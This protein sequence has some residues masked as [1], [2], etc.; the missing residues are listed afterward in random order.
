MATIVTRAGKGSPLTHD[1]VDD[2]FDNL[3]T[4]KVETSAIGTAAAANTGDFATAAQGTLADSAVQT[5]DSPTFAGL[6]TTADV[7][8]GDNDKAIFGAGSDLQIYHDNAQSTNFLI[9][10]TSAN[11]T[12]GTSGIVNVGSSGSN[13][14]VNGAVALVQGNDQVSLSGATVTTTTGTNG[15]VLDNNGSSKLATTATGIDVTGSISVSGTVDGRDV[16]AD[17]TKLDGIEASA[18]VTD[19]ANVTAAG[20]LMDSEVTNLAQVK[21][22]DSS[23]YATAAQGTL[24]DSAVQPNDSPTF[25]AVIATSYAG[26]GSALTGLPAGYTDADVDTHL[27]T[28]TA[29][30]GE[31]LSWTGTDY[32][33]IA[34]GGGGTALELYAEN[35]SSPTAPSATGINATAIG[36]NASATGNWSLAFGRN[37]SATQNYTLALG[38]NSDADGSSSTSIGLN[39]TAG[40]LYSTALGVSGGGLGS[41]TATG[42]GAMALGGSYASGTDSFAAAIANNSA[43]YG[44]TGANSVAMGLNNK[45]TGTRSVAIGGAASQATGSSS[46]ILGGFSSIASGSGSV[47]LGGASLVSSGNYAVSAGQL[48]TASGY[49]AVSMGRSNTAA[50]NYSTVFGYQ[51]STSVYGHNALASGQFSAAG[52]AQAGT[53]ILRSDTTDATAE[54]LTTNNSTAGTT[55]QVI[56]PNNSAYS[57]SGTIIARE[58]ASAGS[59]YASWEIKGAL[60]RDANAASTVLGNGIQNKLYA[61]SGASA[62]DIALTADTTNGGLKIEVTGAAATNIRWV[63]TVNTSEVT[64]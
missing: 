12:I 48:C 35:P 54:A 5:N 27:N 40:S 37:S 50:G 11:M 23:D 42:G 64:Y 29:T 24:A 32:D 36:T 1:E 14:N 59:D 25:G 34:A 41:V 51:A 8:F 26:D 13:V 21:A 18:D 17:G 60:L 4:D 62:W 7:S 31:V 63:A 16:A 43:S 46:V 2:N 33:W 15:V 58:Q 57:F 55:N 61:T 39:T 28:S 56:L 38:L 19:T 44:A 6:T 52:D 53:L 47:T 3:N 30:N 20:A 22:F 45:T 10:Q 49:A 9:S